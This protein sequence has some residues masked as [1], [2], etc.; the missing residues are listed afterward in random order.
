MKHLKYF[1]SEKFI[2]PYTFNNAEEPHYAEYYFTNK[3]GTEYIL[4]F[5]DQLFMYKTKQYDLK[6]TNEHDSENVLNTITTI[7][8]DYLLHYNEDDLYIDNMHSDKEQNKIKDDYPKNFFN[9]SHKIISKRTILMSE[10]LIK[11]LPKKYKFKPDRLSINL[12]H[13]YKK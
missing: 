8:S 9:K 1:E 2:Y 4:V 12:L 11:N 3:Y 5:Q 13:I 7:I 6:Y 10:Y